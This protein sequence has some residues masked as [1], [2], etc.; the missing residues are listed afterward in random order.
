MTT[1]RTKNEK[2]QMLPPDDW[3]DGLGCALKTIRR[4]SDKDGGFGWFAII[5]HSVEVI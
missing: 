3:G 2:V 4:H 5:E 1:W